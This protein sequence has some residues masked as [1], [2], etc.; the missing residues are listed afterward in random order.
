MVAFY[1]DSI[2][3]WGSTTPP[4]LVLLVQL[5]FFQSFPTTSRAV[6]AHADE[7]FPSPIQYACSVVLVWV[8]SGMAFRLRKLNHS[9]D[10]Y[11]DRCRA[12]NGG[13]PAFRLMLETDSKRLGADWDTNLSYQERIG[14]YERKW[15]E[16]L[17]AP[18]SNM[19]HL[20]VEVME[21]EN[22]DS[23][24]P[25]AQFGG[26]PFKALGK[27][28]DKHELEGEVV[29]QFLKWRAQKANGQKG[30]AGRKQKKASERK[31]IGQ[32]PGMRK[33]FE[34]FT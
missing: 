16:V 11:R 26:E 34:D 21:R 5:Q 30:I 22:A 10:W 14:P 15:N 7:N 12:E 4:T 19:S 6:S 9:P 13:S 18:N 24:R 32:L 20:L 1:G 17:S 2:I 3:S 23:Y 8:S 31:F 25:S 29:R 28:L 33:S 27:F